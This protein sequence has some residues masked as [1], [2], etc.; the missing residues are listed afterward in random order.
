MLLAGDVGGTKT[1]VALFTA[2]GTRLRLVEEQRLPSREYRSLTRLVQAAIGR[3]AG[4]FQAA[5]FGVAGPVVNGQWCEA[6]NLPWR[7][8]AQALARTLRTPRVH[9]LND[10]EAL[11]YSVPHLPRTQ[12]FTVSRGRPVAHG[13]I[14]VIAAGTGL[15]EA[16]LCWDGT[17]Y[18]AMPSEGGHTEFGPRTALEIELLRHLQQRFRHVSYERIVSGP[19][20]INLYEFLRDTGRGKETAALRARLRASDYSAGISEA[21][22]DG[23]SA[24]CAKTLEVFMSIYGAEAGNL[25]LK[26]LATGG[27]YVGGGIAPTLLKKFQDGTFMRGFVDKGRF[28]RFMRQLPVHVILEQRAGLWGAARYAAQLAAR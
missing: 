22:L 9:L 7:I 25:A 3:H 8:D 14:A 16:A 10:L 23:T 11:A 20:K 6:T 24:L 12:L 4:R 26:V 28:Q 19:G 17:G 27:V 2:R 5:C 13:A 21:G 1:H 18:R 15:G